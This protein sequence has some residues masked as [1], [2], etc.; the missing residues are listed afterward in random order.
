MK[1]ITA[2]QHPAQLAARTQ[3][4]TNHRQVEWPTIVWPRRVQACMH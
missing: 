1:G 4:G 3:S 2:D